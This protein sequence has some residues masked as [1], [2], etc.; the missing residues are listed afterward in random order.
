MR[1]TCF[2]AL[3]LLCCIACHRP[4]PLNVMYPA[5]GVDITDEGN[6]LRLD[7]KGKH[8]TYDDLFAGARFIWLKSMDQDSIGLINDIQVYQHNYYLLDYGQQK[9]LSFDPEGNPRFTLSASDTAGATLKKIMGFSI[10]TKTRTLEVFDGVA[11]KV[12]KYSFDG[13]PA[14]ELAFPY[15][16]R[17]VACNAQGEYIVYAPGLQNEL[18]GKR[19]GAAVFSVKEDGTFGREMMDLQTDFPIEYFPSNCLSGF[20]DSITLVS[21]YATAAFRFHGDK[22]TRAF[23]IDHGEYWFRSLHTTGASGSSL[24]LDYSKEGKEGPVSAQCLVLEDGKRLYTDSVINNFFPLAVGIPVHFS[25]SS[26]M[27]GL[28]PAKA[29]ARIGDPAGGW[30]ARSPQ[31]ND[32]L[33]RVTDLQQRITDNSDAVI[34]ELPLK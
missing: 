9:L 12:L 11:K 24:V 5:P 2:Q 28:L 3:L 23:D 22:I 13:K 8:F 6:H 33:A 19:S 1:S 4:Q 30:T 20:G 34:I 25:S 18:N 7:E 15:N 21:N 31:Y 32:I 17:E 26:A 27:T 16:Y 10:N 14:G 29:F